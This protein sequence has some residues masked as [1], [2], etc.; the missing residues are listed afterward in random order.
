MPS[1]EHE[2]E[3]TAPPG[4]VWK[5]IYDPEQFV[6]WW[7]CLDAPDATAPTSHPDLGMPQVVGSSRDEGRITVSCMVSDIGFEW[8]L[9]ERDGGGTRVG[10]RVEVPESYGL[11][12]EAQRD[13]IAYSMQ[14][15]ARL[16]E[17]EAAPAT[18]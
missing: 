9:D 10:L 1:Y 6:R 7:G 4:E 15:L 12:A 17:G 11:K 14:K 3:T 18:A 5:L 13:L 8:L 2:V 16:A